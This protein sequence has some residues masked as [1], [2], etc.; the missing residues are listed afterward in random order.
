MFAVYPLDAEA[1]TVARRKARA[2][3]AA[4]AVGVGAPLECKFCQRS[5]QKQYNLLIHER[6]HRGEATEVM[7]AT[8]NHAVCDI[9][10][11]VFKK[12]DTMRN[13]R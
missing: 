6:T 10:G 4:T 7:A 3:A 5:F 11:K 2:V 1:R 12:V 13:H 8:V 9:C